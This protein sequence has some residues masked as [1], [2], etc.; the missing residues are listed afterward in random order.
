MSNY[1][2]HPYCSN[3][4]LS[5]MAI[6]LGLRPPLPGDIKE[7]YR[8]G[9]LFD[10]VVTEPG[11]IDLI[12]MKCGEYSFTKEEHRNCNAMHEALLR[13]SL[14][15]SLL[16]CKPEYQREIYAD[17]VEFE[18]DGNRFY[19]NMKGKLDYFIPGMVADLKSTATESQ[20]AF[21]A[22]C[23][24]FEYWR[25]MVLYCRLAGVK[26]AMIFGVS[27]VKH[28]VFT[29]L[30]EQGDERWKTGEKQLNELAYKYYLVT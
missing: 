3:S 8:I 12:Q 17:N 28:K 19:L 16:D 10:A 24:Q 26:R 5:K 13:N 23:E 27:K 11:L 29:A 1:F 4:A 30:V 14:Y 7:A 18:H 6:E 25:Q 15:Q 9:S 22:A 20:R 21:E 2:A